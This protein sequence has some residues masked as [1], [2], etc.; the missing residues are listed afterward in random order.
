MHIPA[1]VTIKHIE[2]HE[3]ICASILSNGGIKMKDFVVIQENVLELIYVFLK[4]NTLY[5]LNYE[6]AKREHCN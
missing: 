5:Q 6:E 1:L 4:D 2:T 3:T